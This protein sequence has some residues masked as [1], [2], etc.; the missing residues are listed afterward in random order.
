MTTFAEAMEKDA[1]RLIGVRRGDKVREYLRCA[2]SS[3]LR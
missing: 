2:R 3:R 1:D